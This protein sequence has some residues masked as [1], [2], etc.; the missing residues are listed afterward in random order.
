MKVLSTTSWFMSNHSCSD[1]NLQRREGIHIAHAAQR[2]RS[3]AD[4]EPVGLFGGV[5]QLGRV[6][7][8]GIH[9]GQ[10]RQ[11]PR[12]VMMRAIGIRNFPGQSLI[13]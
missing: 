3:R 12:V 9:P 5:A 2:H 6:E 11:M 13:R 10:V 1:A 7:P 8:R 4:H